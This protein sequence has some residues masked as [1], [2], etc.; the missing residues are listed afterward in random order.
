MPLEPF[1]VKGQLWLPPDARA[2]NLASTG[3]RPAWCHPGHPDP[4]HCGG[5]R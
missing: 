4:I 5:A 3:Y 1:G 2:Y